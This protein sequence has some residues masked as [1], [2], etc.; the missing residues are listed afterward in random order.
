VEY[1]P[2]DCNENFG[3][4]EVPIKIELQINSGFCAPSKTSELKE[5]NNFRAS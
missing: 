3:E 4:D 2:S 1:P 5:K